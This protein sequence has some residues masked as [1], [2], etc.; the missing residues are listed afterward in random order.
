MTEAEGRDLVKGFIE[1]YRNDVIEMNAAF[2]AALKECKDRLR[3]CIR[4]H[5]TPEQREKWDELNG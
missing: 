1:A 3:D 5:L 2:K 4:G